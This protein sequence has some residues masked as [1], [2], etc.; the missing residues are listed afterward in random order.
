MKYFIVLVMMFVTSLAFSESFTVQVEGKLTDEQ[1]AAVAL[2]AQQKAAEPVSA[3]PTVSKVKEWVDIGGAIGA[4]LASSAKELGIAANTFAQTP[5]GKF[6][7]VMIAWHFI[8]AQLIHVGIG[9]LWLITMIPLWVF[10]YK[11]MQFNVT[12]K[13]Y[14]KG[15]G[16]NGARKI[17][18]R[19]V[20]RVADG[21]ELM[22]WVLLAA[23]IL[24]G[25]IA[26]FS[27]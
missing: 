17:V 22:Y 18:E 23:I 11:R 26:I 9:L 6:T 7:V 21:T 24:I 2:V 8:G 4:G 12:V 14:N 10:L 15:E 13:Y 1:R 27:F 19:T 5:V 25:V 20:N 16:P 3:A